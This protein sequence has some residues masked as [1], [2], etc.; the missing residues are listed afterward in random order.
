MTYSPVSKQYHSDLIVEEAQNGWRIVRLN[1]PKS[2]HALD[3][4]IA[5][6]LLEVFEDFHHDDNVKA[7][8]FDSTTPKAFCAGGDVRKLR[9]LVINDE[10]ATANKFFEQEYALDL[11]LH[12]YAKP[13]LVWGEG[14]VMGGGLGLFMAAPFRLVTPYSR[15]AMPEINIGLYPDVGATRFLADRGAIGLFT[16]L[17]GSIMTAAGAYG[18]GWATHICDMQRDAVLHK[19]VNVDWEHYPAGDFRAIDDTLNSMHRPVGPG[20]LQNSLD[21]I[22]SVCRGVNFEHDYEAIVGLKDARSDW[23]RQASE[24]LQKGSPATAALTWLLWQWGK[25]VHSWNEVFELEIQ[26][27]DWK[28]RHPDFVE[29][30]RARLVDKDL[31]P[32]WE[33]GTDLSLKGIFGNNPPVTQIDSWNALLR[34]YGVIS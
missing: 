22:H 11:L 27:S 4:T 31:S 23:L 15:L 26:I 1:R 17:T 28:I 32:E 13:V 21:V 9:Q 25:Q 19:M 3:E 29:G 20:P 7:I 6:A 34:Q 14:Y 5:S 2:L 16:G 33:K 10:V 12:N 30:V 18:I 8:W 24:N